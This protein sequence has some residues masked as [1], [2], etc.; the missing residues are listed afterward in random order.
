MSDADRAAQSAAICAQLMRLDHFASA[1]V[2]LLYRPLPREV[3]VTAVWHDAAR[4][5]C[6]IFFPR[7]Q[8]GDPPLA[9]VCVAHADDWCASSRPFPMPRAGLPPLTDRDASEAVCIVPGLAFAAD[10]TRLGRGG[11]HY[12]RAL[13]APPIAGRG[14]RIGVAFAQ[15]MV[16]SIPADL[17]DVRMNAVVTPSKI[18]L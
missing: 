17:H 9:F 13:A 18:W 11:G 3:N 10:G 2:V 8:E 5:G 14:Y 7:L 15:Q 12:D 1:A 16:E 4:R 6:R